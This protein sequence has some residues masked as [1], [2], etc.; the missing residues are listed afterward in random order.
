MFDCKGYPIIGGLSSFVGVDA[1]GGSGLGGIAELQARS[2]GFDAFS[3]VRVELVRGWDIVGL[4]VGLV[5]LRGRKCIVGVGV[6]IGSVRVDHIDVIVVVGGHVV[7]PHLVIFSPISP[8]SADRPLQALQ[9]L[10]DPSPKHKSERDAQQQQQEHH[11]SY[12]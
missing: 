10:L 5:I 12:Y 9:P 8:H 7:I 2:C 1:L 4:Q 11:I 6:N 3:F